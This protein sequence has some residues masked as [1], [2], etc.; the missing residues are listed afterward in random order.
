MR[1]SIKRFAALTVLFAACLFAGFDAGAGQLMK[2]SFINPQAISLCVS[3][4]S[5]GWTNL[6]SSGYTTNSANIAWTN[7]T[8]TVLVTGTNTG[9]DSLNMLG[10][11]PLWGDN[12]PWPWTAIALTNGYCTNYSSMLLTIKLTGGSGANSAVSFR[13]VALGDGVNENTD[14][15]HTYTA[16]VTANTTTPVVQS[17]YLPTSF[18]GGVPAI[19]LKSI[20]NADTDASSAV[21]VQSITLTGFSP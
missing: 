15:T 17:F 21:W 7:Y 16:A 19:R 2:Y 18:T 20:D 11:I 13:F 4:N 9:N 12:T 1:T 6:N 5:M 3:N 8:G 10:T 14:S